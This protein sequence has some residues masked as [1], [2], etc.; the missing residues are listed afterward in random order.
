MDF[1]GI[2]EEI[3][4][5]GRYQKIN[6]LLICLPVMFAAANS[7]S[8]VFTAGI[9]NYRCLIPEC[10]ESSTNF[11]LNSPWLVNATPGTNS[12]GKF[13]PEKCLRYEVLNDTSASAGILTGACS[14]EKF[15][16]MSK[17]RCHEWVFDTQEYTI[18]QEWELTCSENAWKLALVGTMH[19]AG[20]VAGTATSGFFADR[21]GRKLIF[22]VCI[23]FMAITGILQGIAWDYNSFIVFA[24]L[25][26]VG[27]SAV[28]PLA[29]IIGVEMVGPKR[30]EM[31]SIVL[32]YFYAVGEALVGLAAWL[33]P[34]WQLLQIVLSAPPLIFIA[35]YWMVPESVRWLIAR[36]DYEKAKK[37]ITKAAKTNK[38]ELSVTLLDSFDNANKRRRGRC[39]ED[40]NWDHTKSTS[41]TNS[42]NIRF[43]SDEKGEIY[44]AVRDV[45]KSKKLCIRYALLLYIWGVNALVFYGLSLNSTN[46]SGNKYINFALV[47]LVEIPGYSLAWVMLNKFGRRLS[48]TGSL[49]L[50]AVTCVAG[51]YVARSIEWAVIT[52]FLIGKLGI[53]SSF[54]IL[55]TYTAEMMPTIIRSGGVGCMSTFARFGAMLAPFVPLLGMYYETLPLLVFGTIS[56]SAGLLGLFLPETFQ[57]KLPDTVKEAK[58]LLSDER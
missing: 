5:C 30:R 48:L 9:P 28:Y 38:K 53:T 22:I 3:G 27:T 51:G 20:L 37:I 15:N 19:F 57:K 2:L 17:V 4:E 13:T 55:Y 39:E 23:V 47:C 8:Y 42:D 54:A 21:Y 14:K 29:F 40:K 7:L 36:E 11:E 25:N 41:S 49:L 33:L 32:N 1:D 6:Y 52:L 46:L 31:A 12:H 45:F 10:G 26:A 24:F 56:L 18:V 43:E 58:S 16:Q 50:C 34:N 35:Y 44:G